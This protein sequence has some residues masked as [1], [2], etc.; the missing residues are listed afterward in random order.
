MKVRNLF[1]REGTSLTYYAEFGDCVS[2]DTTYMTN[3]YNLPF[4]PFCGVTGHGHTCLFGC[5]FLSD[6]TTETF[7]WLFETFSGIHGR[8]APKINNYRP[9]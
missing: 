7:I 6:E 1:W 4:A 9:G 5:G 2:F 3:K 8:E